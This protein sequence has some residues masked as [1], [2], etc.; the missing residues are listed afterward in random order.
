MSQNEMLE[1]LLN[2]FLKLIIASEILNVD[3]DYK[4]IEKLTIDFNDV[5]TELSKKL[6]GGNLL[7][8][9]VGSLM[10]R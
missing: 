6:L 2:N 3:I 5:I 1:D 4:L 8:I 7:V 10:K 9:K